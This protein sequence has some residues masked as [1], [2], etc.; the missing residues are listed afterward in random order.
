MISRSIFLYYW[1]GTC[2]RYLQ[3]ARAGAPI[4]GVGH[5]REN[6]DH[7]FSY[8][9][10]LDLLVTQRASEALKK[11]SDQ[12]P[13][14]DASKLS[15]EQGVEL[16]R[17]MTEI[18]TTLEAELEGFEAFVITP[19]RLDVKRLLTDAGSLLAPG[20]YDK[21]PPIAQFDLSEAGKCTAFERPTA[22][23]FHLLRATERVLVAFY[24]VLA[25][26]NRVSR[27]WGPM[28]IDLRKRKNA[29]K[30]EVLLNNLDNIRKSFRNPTQHPELTYDIHETQDL[31]GLC[32]EAIGRMAKALP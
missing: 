9:K 27:M 28:V 5:I 24:E 1:F 18:R 22:A 4:T 8:L 30:H 16:N 19:K 10:N 11:F 3:D 14:D 7:F 12:L 2:I 26:H 20:V 6:L 13:K 31:W 17:L 29:K 21:L 15:Y 32:I 25:R 23:A